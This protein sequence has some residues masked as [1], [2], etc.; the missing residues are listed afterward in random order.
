MCIDAQ[1]QDI[2]ISPNWP[3]NKPT[4]KLQQQKN[5]SILPKLYYDTQQWLRCVD[6]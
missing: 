1:G 5:C 4:R 6:F 2:I 3:F